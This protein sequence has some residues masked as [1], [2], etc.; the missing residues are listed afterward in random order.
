V[1][2]GHN[3]TWHCGISGVSH[4]YTSVMDT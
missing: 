2:M 3:I 1:I 4:S